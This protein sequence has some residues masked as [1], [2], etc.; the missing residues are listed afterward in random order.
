MKIICM[1][2]SSFYENKGNICYSTVIN[3]IFEGIGP[4]EYTK[5]AQ[6]FEND[7]NCQEYSRRNKIQKNSVFRSESGVERC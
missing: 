7:S 4:K 5:S 3:K 1:G 2:S 6:K